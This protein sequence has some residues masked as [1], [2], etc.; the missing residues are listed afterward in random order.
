MNCHVT[1]YSNYIKMHS[2]IGKNEFD[3]SVVILLMGR[4]EEVQLQF[5][6]KKTAVH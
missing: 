5:K 1:E 2:I 3:Y 4:N 6:S